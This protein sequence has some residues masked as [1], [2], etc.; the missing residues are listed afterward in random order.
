MHVPPY[1]R[2]CARE[3]CM[4]CGYDTM[5]ASL[6]LR[7][8]VRKVQRLSSCSGGRDSSAGAARSSVVRA[9]GVR[10]EG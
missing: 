4:Y 1:G 10:R 3:V 5:S 9:C 8:S 2:T 7:A 6:P